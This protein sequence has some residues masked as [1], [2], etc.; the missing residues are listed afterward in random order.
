MSCKKSAVLERAGSEMDAGKSLLKR[1]PSLSHRATSFIYTIAMSASVSAPL[2]SRRPWGTAHPPL[3]TS[4]PLAT[5]TL[6]QPPVF[7]QVCVPPSGTTPE[8]AFSQKRWLLGSC[9]EHGTQTKLKLPIP[10]QSRMRTCFCWGRVIL[11]MADR[12]AR[13]SVNCP[14]FALSN[15]SCSDHQ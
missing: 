10:G 6:R 9:P 15:S 1:V 5:S 11:L 4:C 8:G 2:P 14:R 7:L 12:Y 3:C 13:Y